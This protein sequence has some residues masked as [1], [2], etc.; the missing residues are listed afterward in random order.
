MTKFSYNQDS[1]LKAI[2]FPGETKDE[3]TYAYNDA[4][5]MSEVKMKQSTEV[6]ASLVYTRDNDGQVKKTTSKGLPGTE[7]TENTYDE[8]NRLTKYGSTEYKYD[9]ANNPTTEGSST[10][11]YNEG[12]ELEKG[13]GTT[14]AY[15]ELGERTK[16]TPEK[17]GATTYGYDQ[18]GNL[19]SVERPEKESV[20]KIEDSYAYNG[21]GLR[22]SQTISGTTSYLAW[23]MTEELP[24]ILG[25]GTNSYIYGPDGLPIEQISSGGTV[26]YL[27]HD[28]QG[29]TRLLTGSTGTVTGKCTYGP[30]GTPTCEGTS[31]TPLGYD[32]Q[33]TSSDT[34]LIYMRARVYDP[35][36]AQFLSVPLDAITRAP[37]YYAGDNPLNKADPTGLIELS[38]CENRSEYEEKEKRIQ[39]AYEEK[40]KTEKEIRREAETEASNESEGEQ[41]NNHIQQGCDLSGP[42]VLVGLRKVPGVAQATGAFCVGFTGARLLTGQNVGG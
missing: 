12:D 41:I 42:A 14:Y 11:T 39:R 28:Q 34:G 19:T 26:S 5:F 6:L 13:T 37:Y 7:V 4:D 24:L 31:T 18:A 25:D 2:V 22:T 9:A 36:T 20:P 38:P 8:N 40:E 21:E 32:G 29:S 1:D 27:H 30:Y 10:N 33:Y 35:T 17:G 15:D 3:D 23:D 16:T